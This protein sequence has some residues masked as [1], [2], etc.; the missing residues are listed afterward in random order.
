MSTLL[1][2][3]LVKYF[4][5]FSSGVPVPLGNKAIEEIHSI[6]APSP[7]CLQR[8]KRVSEVDGKKI[9]FKASVLG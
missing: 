4:Y 7:S 1:P 9:I 2:L 3:G 5:S 6:P 8:S